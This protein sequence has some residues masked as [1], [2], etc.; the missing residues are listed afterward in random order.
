LNS[1][2]IPQVIEVWYLGVHFEKTHRSQ[3]CTS[4]TK[5]QQLPLGL[6]LDYMVLLHNSTLKPIWTGTQLWGNASSSNVDVI[7]RAQSK[8]LR[9]ITGA[10]WYTRNQNIHRDLGVVAVKDEIDKQK[11]SYNEKLS[12]LPNRLARGLTWV[13]QIPLSKNIICKDAV[14]QYNRF[15]PGHSFAFLL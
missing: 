10:P 13:S 7:Q 4:N 2:Q 11:G 9:T 5:V 6:R 1:K 8:I 15:F 3:E 14:G 12:M